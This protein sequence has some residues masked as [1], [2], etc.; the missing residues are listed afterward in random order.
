MLQ[1]GE[2]GVVTCDWIPSEQGSRTISVELDRANIILES[3]ED[4]NILTATVE[5]SA[6]QPVD[7][8][9]GADIS[10]STLWILTLVTIALLIVSFTIFAPKKIK[11]L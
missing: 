6:A 4:N 9:S 1:P 11:K 5:V 10:T 2:L 7:S 3:D 8:S